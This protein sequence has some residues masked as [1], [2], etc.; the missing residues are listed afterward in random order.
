MTRDD[1]AYQLAGQVR[2]ASCADSGVV[3]DIEHG[4][5]FRLNCVASR[6]L[7]LVKSGL[8]ESEI[9]AKIAEEFG[10]DFK[11]VECDTREFLEML[12]RFDVIEER[13]AGAVGSEIWA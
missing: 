11:T 1:R 5:M 6:M 13:S 2:S 12:E 4:R 9:A 8:Q 3:L 7:K 10:I